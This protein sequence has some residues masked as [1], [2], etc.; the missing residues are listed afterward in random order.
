MSA[1]DDEAQGDG[2][3][4]PPCFMHEVDPAYMGLPDV[5]QQTDVNRWRKAERER[6]LTIRQAI[7]AEVRQAAMGRI[8][9]HLDAAFGD[10]AARTISFYWPFRGEPDLRDLMARVVARGGQVAL[11]VVIAKGQPMVFRGWRPGEPLDRGVW[12]IPVPRD[13]AP[14]VQPDIVI[15][16]V[17]G[18][19]AAC[20]RLGYGGGFFDRTLA[21]MATRPRVIGV[22]YDLSAIQ[23][24]FPQT[25]DIPMDAVVTESGAHTPRTK[26][27]P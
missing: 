5:Q 17:V 12:N 20:Y 2:F 15:A 14:V 3:A 19:D 24:I 1:H 13:N 10:V 4:S 7:P 18:F 27:V 21:A 25:Y 9:T 8:T 16:P 22:G 23:T 26:H 6:L 11:P